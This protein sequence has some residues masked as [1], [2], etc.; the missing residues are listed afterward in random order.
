MK[1]DK[2][3]RCYNC[4]KFAHFAKEC[5]KE[6]GAK[7]KAHSTHNDMSDPE[8]MILMASI[9]ENQSKDVVWYLDSGC[10]MHM[11]GRKEGI[12]KMK[13]VVHDRS[14]MLTIW[15]E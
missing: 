1:V 6:D 8:V 12:V 13:E 5:W 14:N 10:S 11:I 2:K 3:I 4:Q 9:N 7:N 15:V